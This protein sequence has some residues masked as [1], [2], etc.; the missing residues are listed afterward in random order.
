[1]RKIVMALLVLCIGGQIFA[2]NQKVLFTA[3]L[4][5]KEVPEVILKAV[6]RDFSNLT[7]IE[8]LSVPESFVVPSS[9]DVKDVKFNEYD[10]FIVTFAGKTAKIMA[11][12]DKDGKL[13][14]S[15]DRYE[16]RNAPNS[17][18]YSIDKLFPEWVIKDG[19][20]KMSTYETSGKV[21]NEFYKLTIEN[22]SKVRKVYLNKD[23]K[24]LNSLGNTKKQIT[25]VSRL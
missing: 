20:K 8:Y 16:T 21:K 18:Y 10:S 4:N 19:Y 2:Q 14:S 24:F 13:V 5:K 1:M 23:G 12:Y 9:L 7:A 3:K 17:I 15:V 11:T 22:G 25:I 6:D